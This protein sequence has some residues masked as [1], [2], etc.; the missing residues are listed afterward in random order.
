MKHAPKK[1]FI[2]EDDE[3]IEISY[4]EFCQRK[5]TD[6]TYKDNLFIFLHGMLM[7]VTEE[8]YRNFYKSNREFMILLRNF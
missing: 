2:L 1:V 7:E 6:T 4:E 3:Y 8:T 5:E